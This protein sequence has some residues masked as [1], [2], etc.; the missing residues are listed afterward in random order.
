MSLSKSD[1][2]RLRDAGFI[3]EEIDRIGKAVTPGG[4]KQPK[5]DIESDAWSKTIKNRIRQRERW[6]KKGLT[7]WQ[8]DEVLR[9]YYR[10]KAGAPRSP[11]DFI[12]ALYVPEKG[13]TDYAYAIRRRHQQRV[14]QGLGRAVKMVTEKRRR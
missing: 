5:V 2:R 8:Q 9:T 3:P 1:S 7:E 11:Y 6:A 14:R 4:V 10:T 12:K 13:L